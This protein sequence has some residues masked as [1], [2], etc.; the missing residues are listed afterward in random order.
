ML[1]MRLQR[2]GKTNYA[3]YRVVVAEHTA[4]V[5]GRFIEDLGYYNPHEK[6]FVVDE[7]KVAA[8]MGKGVQTSATVHNLLIN[9]NIIKGEKKL[10]W[11][12]KKKAAGEEQPAAT[13]TPTPEA[14]DSEKPK[15]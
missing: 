3:T 13:A 2:R 7:D 8:W 9:H 12:P 14:P 15:E 10:S 6:K 4:P 5:K 11:R 1:K